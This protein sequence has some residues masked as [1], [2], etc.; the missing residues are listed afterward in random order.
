[1]KENEVNAKIQAIGFTYI[2]MCA[3]PGRVRKFRWKP[4]S[5]PTLLIKHHQSSKFV[6]LYRDGI[7]I[8]IAKYG[9]FEKFIQDTQEVQRTIAAGA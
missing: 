9:I 2:G 6:Q 1:M 5:G 8:N 4:G 7:Q 3:C